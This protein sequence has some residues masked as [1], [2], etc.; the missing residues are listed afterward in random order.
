M[1]RRPH[2]AGRGGAAGGV[3]AQ[4]GFHALQP[5]GA[6]RPGL[7]YSY[8][9][10]AAALGTGLSALLMAVVLGA[11]SDSGG[12]TSRRDPRP[13]QAPSEPVIEARMMERW[14]VWETLPEAPPLSVEEYKTLQRR[15]KGCWKAP[16]D[17]PMVEIRVEFEP[18][19]VP[20]SSQI[21]DPEVM[22]LDPSFREVA[23]TAR[24]A[25][26]SCGHF[27]LPPEKYETWREI[28]FSFTP[29]RSAGQQLSIELID[30]IRQQIMKCWN[31]PASIQN[32]ADATVEVSVL[33]TPDGVVE[34]A[35]V[36][37]RTI[38]SGNP[39][40]DASAKA[41][42]QAVEQCS[43]LVGLPRTQ[44]ASWRR[45]VFRFDPSEFLEQ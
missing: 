12:S 29:A 34:Q 11:C 9:M 44:Y 31:P 27:Q 28:V 20:K 37:G 24:R 45:I 33:L 1:A 6:T 2:P 23:L 38:R 30:T 8:G 39:D 15:L 4:A 17:G 10:R 5:G 19:G 18:S 43:P 42:V 35:E 41:A 21:L 26:E 3:A 7:R 40:F 16:S 36:S 13:I 22:A 25:I 32:A 14:R